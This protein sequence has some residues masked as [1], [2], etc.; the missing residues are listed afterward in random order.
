MR[1][2]VFS[3]AVST[4]HLRIARSLDWKMRTALPGPTDPAGLLQNLNTSTILSVRL[5]VQD[6]FFVTLL[7]AL[8]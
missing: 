6:Y 5:C 3:Q 8:D 7:L 1:D 4:I 2:K